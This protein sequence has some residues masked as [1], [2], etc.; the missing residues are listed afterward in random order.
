MV[1]QVYEG[2]GGTEVFLSAEDA[3]NDV[4]FG[5]CR[6]RIPGNP[7][8]KEITAQS[9]GIRELHVYGSAAPLGEQGNIQHRGIGKKLLNT[10]EKLAVESYDKHKMVVISGI[11]VREYYRKFGYRKQGPYM[12]KKLN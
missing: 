10:A 12:V 5:F 3:K 9:A 4:L 1:K 11:G 8:R 7:Y 2:S 6:L